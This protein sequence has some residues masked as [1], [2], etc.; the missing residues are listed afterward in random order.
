M[1]S[2]FEFLFCTLIAYSLY[3]YQYIRTTQKPPKMDMNHEKL[4]YDINKYV[5][6]SLCNNTNM[7]LYTTQ[8][9]KR[10]D[11][12]YRGQIMYGYKHGCGSMLFSNGYSYEGI[13]QN[14]TANG[15]G[16]YIDNND[17]IL[18]SGN[19]KYN[20]YHGLVKFHIDT[21]FNTNVSKFNC[22]YTNG[23]RKNCY[24]EYI[25]NELTY[26]LTENAMEE[27]E[28]FNAIRNL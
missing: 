24:V 3:K 9:T 25:G 11:S 20:R 15:F 17:N 13:W 7:L 14:D 23:I 1:A 16:M 27:M 28:I 18:I 6:N 19:K 4:L 22:L 2:L 21:L 26:V 8:I 5:Y 10:D 12:I